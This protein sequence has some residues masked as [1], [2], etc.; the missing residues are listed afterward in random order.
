MALVVVHKCLAIHRVTQTGQLLVVQ[1]QGIAKGKFHPSLL[2]L[3]QGTHRLL[4]CITQHVHSVERDQRINGSLKC[5]VKIQSA[6]VGS[7]ATNNGTSVTGQMLTRNPSHHEGGQLLCLVQ[8]L[9][10]KLGVQSLDLVFQLTDTTIQS[11]LIAQHGQSV[12]TSERTVLNHSSQVSLAQ[13]S[14]HGAPFF[15]SHLTGELLGQSLR[16]LSTEL[17]TQTLNGRTNLLDHV[18]EVSV[19][20]NTT[21]QV[22]NQ[23]MQ[24][25]RQSLESIG[26]SQNGFTQQTS[27]LFIDDGSSYFQTI[28]DGRVDQFTILTSLATL[29]SQSGELVSYFVHALNDSGIG[30][31][32]QSTKRSYILVIEP[33]GLLSSIHELVSQVINGLLHVGRTLLT[34]QHIGELVEHLVGLV[35]K[36]TVEGTLLSRRFSTGHWQFSQHFTEGIVGQSQSHECRHQGRAANWV[37]AHT[38]LPH[39]NFVLLLSLSIVSRVVTLR[40]PHERFNSQ[41]ASSSRVQLLHPVHNSRIQ[42]SL[43]TQSSHHFVEGVCFLGSHREAVAREQANHVE[44]VD[45]RQGNLIGTT[46]L[47]NRTLCSHIVSHLLVEGTIQICQ[48]LVMPIDT[49]HHQRSILGHSRQGRLSSRHHHLGVISQVAQHV[50]GIARV[51]TNQPVPN[52]LQSVPHDSSELD[53]HLGLSLCQVL[54]SQTPGHV[55]VQ[56]NSLTS[57]LILMRI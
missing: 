32:S 12:G 48:T 30:L 11:R 8:V 24:P 21:Y 6:V 15:L 45:T 17:V 39:H 57:G 4:V 37:F 25:F 7:Q 55:L 31:V 34:R 14:V 19:G 16:Q 43:S 22:S 33:L 54:V 42:L 3:N 27:L 5:R 44:G 41:L 47:L 9:F 20:I 10:S 26:T 49:S 29:L 23:V 52:C 38:T 51:G 36:Q 2:A 53:R 28:V 40:I 13:S 1:T 18:I 50:I 56:S 35:L 46:N